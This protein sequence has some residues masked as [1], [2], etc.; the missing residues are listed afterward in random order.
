M[1]Q[2]GPPRVSAGQGPIGYERDL[3]VVRGTRVCYRTLGQPLFHIV[4][5]PTKTW[6]AREASGYPIPEEQQDLCG[7]QGVVQLPLCPSTYYTWY[8]LY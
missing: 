6:Q 4:I 3:V 8:K 5:I 1:G 7:H 2:E